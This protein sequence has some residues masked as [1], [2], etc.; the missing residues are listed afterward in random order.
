MEPRASQS[1]S[2]E[3][4]EQRKPSKMGHLTQKLQ[5]QSGAESPLRRFAGRVLESWWV[6]MLIVFLTLADVG[7]VAVESAIDLHLVCIS[8][9]SVAMPPADVVGLVQNAP[10]TLL[11]EDVVGSSQGDS[12]LVTG[13]FARRHSALTVLS[14]SATAAAG[15][16]AGDKIRQDSVWLQHRKEEA[17]ALICED[18][19]GLQSSRLVHAAHSMSVAILIVFFIE[20][21]LK[22]WLHPGGFFSNAFHI[23][24]L[25][26]VTVS[27][28]CDA[29]L[30]P[31]L[32]GS[33]AL[34]IM[35][36][37]AFLVIFRCW[38]LV[39]MAHGLFEVV[40]EEAEYMEELKAEKAR[41]EAK[42]LSLE[43]DVRGLREAAA[44]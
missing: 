4:P 23:L 19:E 44:T 29:I 30:E 9:T 26:V 8:G 43:N 20:L 40:H 25:V 13:R 11:Q 5:V 6:D 22:I 17:G 16:T 34:D 3:E 24:D 15:F 2:G 32:E 38:R 18:R 7:C 14:A 21:M 35:V 28:I 31:L 41:L 33:E 37:T 27:L 42:C 1:S 39:R 12:L 36:L 10:N